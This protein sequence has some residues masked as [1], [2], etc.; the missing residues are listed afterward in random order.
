ME[1]GRATAP[2]P[3]AAPGELEM[4]RQLINS[5]SIQRG[6]DELTSIDALAA[7]LHNHDFNVDTTSLTDDSLQL[8]L[9]IR[10]GLRALVMVNSGEP[11]EKT[12]LKGM[13]SVAQR[14]GLGFQVGSDGS[15]SAVPSGNGLERA[16]GKLLLIAYRS[17][18]D[19]TWAR[20]K[21]CSSDSCRY[22]FYDNSKNRT[23]KWCSMAVCGNRNK[24]RK[25]LKEHQA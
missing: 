6:T 7:W 8:F 5:R 23:G 15:L 13:E 18:I 21:A 16:A 1:N 14:L 17:M 19:G 22:A 4:V 24:V 9:R 10:E 11:P 20:L 2:E 3:R 12:A 25:Y